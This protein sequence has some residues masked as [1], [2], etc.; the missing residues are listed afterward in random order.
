MTVPID[1]PTSSRFVFNNEEVAALVGAGV[2][3]A[4]YTLMTFFN[5][6][7]TTLHLPTPVW[8][9]LPIVTTVGYLYVL[10]YAIRL[11]CKPV[12]TAR[13]E[14]L[15]MFVCLL[16]F[17]ALNPMVQ[18]IVLR[19]VHGESMM[20]ILDSLTQPQT[21]PVLEVI[22]PFFL[23]LTGTYFGQLLARVI[24]EPALLVPVGIVGGLIDLWGVYWGPV[25]MM[26]ERAPAAISGMATAATSAAK[27]PESVT[28]PSN[29]AFFGHVAPPDN[30]GIGDFVFL[31]FFLTCAYRFGF[32]AKRTM[33]GIFAGLL[34]ASVVLAFDGTTL[35]GHEIHI[36]YLPG[37]LFIC[38]GVLLA[39][40]DA[41]R[42][43]KQEWIMTAALGIL[44]LTIIGFTALRAEA[45]K[46]HVQTITYDV[47]AATPEA[48]GPVVLAQ[49]TQQPRAPRDLRL[50][51][52]RYIYLRNAVASGPVQAMGQILGRQT[53]VTLSTSREY[54]ISCIRNRKNPTHWRVQETMTSPPTSSLAILKNAAAKPMDA[55]TLLRTAQ[56]VPAPAFSILGHMTKYTLAVTSGHF[57]VLTLL[58]HDATVRDE[59][60]REV[61][62]VTYARMPSGAQ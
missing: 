47:I 40:Y 11:L 23:I 39:N 37:L 51:A 7:S 13:V 46:P 21:H 9:V 41:W 3:L 62:R 42:L 35:F 54:A 16:L 52:M 34:L 43:S 15:F 6:V 56:S 8:L 1:T 29:L 38:G 58:P 50:L 5:T 20:K 48:L 57:V 49:I 60:M 25:G 33:W 17:L 12:L 26:S 36:Q 61:K 53:P 59:R 4:F 45:G 31:A 14:T 55:L 27:L 28:L 30:I 44:L 10:V 19:L 22:V 2:Y 24:R 18:E 32:S